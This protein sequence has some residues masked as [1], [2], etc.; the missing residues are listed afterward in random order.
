MKTAGSLGGSYRLRLSFFQETVLPVARQYDALSMK[1]LTKSTFF[2]RHVL[3]LWAL[4][5]CFCR[6]PDDLESALPKLAP[7]LVRAMNDQRYPELVVGRFKND[8]KNTR[9]YHATCPSHLYFL[10]QILICTGVKTLATGISD[11][12][13]SSEEL[14]EGEEAIIIRQEAALLGKLS[15]KMIPSLFKLVE[16][17]HVANNLDIQ[18]DLEEMMKVETVSTSN[19]DEAAR[20]RGVTETIASLAQLASRQLI[21]NL[22]SKV[23]QKLLEASQADE[24]LSEKMCSLLSLSQALVISDSLDHSSI[25]LLYRSLKPLIRTDRTKPRIQK[26]AY[27]VLAEI[28]NRR[29][30]FVRENNQLKDLLE[31]LTSSTATSQV[32]ARFMRI[33][34]LT[35]IVKSLQDSSDNDKVCFLQCFSLFLQSCLIFLFH[36]SG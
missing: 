30:A 34:C 9:N 19:V 15:E 14:N 22:F 29:G 24:D 26:R 28:C 31:L 33:K 7:L 25:S 11:R 4:F 1:N 10:S 6:N 16:T 17:L 12:L 13:R 5:P 18:N 3:H 27:K 20:V 32:S 23:L 8:E 21:Q 2:R 36:F 35:S